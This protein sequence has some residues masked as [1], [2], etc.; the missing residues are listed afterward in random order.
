M[1]QSNVQKV[2]DVRDER[3]E[4]N[5][6]NNIFC[7][8]IHLRLSW[9]PWI[10]SLFQNQTKNLALICIRIAP[11]FER[12][13]VDISNNLIILN[14]KCITTVKRFPWI[15]PNIGPKLNIWIVFMCFAFRLK[16]L[17]R[18]SRKS[19]F[20][21]VYES[22]IKTIDSKLMLI[23]MKILFT[24]YSLH[25]TLK[26]FDWVLLNKSHSKKY[27]IRNTKTKTVDV[28]CKTSEL[29]SSDP[30]LAVIQ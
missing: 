20:V 6:Y 16:F 23:E 10:N 4:L 13:F 2:R 22:K 15:W 29:V 27:K 14:I 28:R 18:F 26:F 21:L 8:L 1:N 25:C 24:F 19:I 5:A 11:T 3:N 30:I 9:L 17:N 12:T 7:E